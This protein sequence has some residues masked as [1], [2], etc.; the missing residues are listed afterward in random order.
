[1]PITLSENFRAVFYAPF[2]ATS[3]LRHYRDE[4]LDVR[5]VTSPAPG[6]ATAG[7]LDGSIDVTWGGP[8]RVM[9]ARDEP[10][11]PPLVCFCEVARKDPFYLVG[12]PPDGGFKLADLAELRFASVAEVPTP[13]LCLQ[14][15]LREAGIDP[16][17]LDRIA[18][19]SMAQNL[20]ALSRGEIDVAQ[21][22][23]PF[24]AAAI[25]QG[26]GQILHA[27]SS[28]GLTSYT[29]FLTTRANVG[30]L[31]AEFAAMSRAIG[32]TQSWIAE[33][34]ASEFAAVVAPYFPEVPRADLVSALRGYKAAG[35]WD[36]DTRV[37]RDGFERLAASLRSG[38][39]ISHMPEYHDCVA[40]T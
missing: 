13:W 7:L 34:D 11:G 38:G 14:H 16:S 4:G 30:R 23:E 22:F 28:R 17:R 9:K 33:C 21:V 6:L 37:T 20:D 2:Y 24:A 12:R 1:M 8:M 40:E 39:F 25:R 35:L 19:R 27:A 15:D 32:R 36:R 5:L 10:A 18:D 29:T 26:A 3:E 31:G